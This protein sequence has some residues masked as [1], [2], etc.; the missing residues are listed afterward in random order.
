[1]RVPTDRATGKVNSP[2]FVHMYNFF[3]TMELGEIIICALGQIPTVQCNDWLKACV[4]K[5]PSPQQQFFKHLK[6]YDI[7]GSHLVFV[8]PEGSTRTNWFEL[9]KRGFQLNFR[10]NRHGETECLEG[11]PLLEVFKRSLHIHVS[12]NGFPALAA[13]WGLTDLEVFFNFRRE[14]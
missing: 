2:Y 1:M 12:I 9:Q 10:K 11:I 7:N 14:K 4:M 8:V 5:H 3:P 6:G 13:G